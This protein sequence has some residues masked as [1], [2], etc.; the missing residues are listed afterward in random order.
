MNFAQQ[1]KKIR[2]ALNRKPS[3]TLWEITRSPSAAMLEK[4]TARAIL[5]ARLDGKRK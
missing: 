2:K 5:D 1:S 3:R 4:T